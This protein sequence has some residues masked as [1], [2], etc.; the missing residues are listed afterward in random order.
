MMTLSI[1]SY[2]KWSNDS[3]TLCVID[4]SNAVK[5]FN[6]S[7]KAQNSTLIVK[8]I[9]QDAMKTIECDAAFFSNTSALTEQKLINT[10][11]KKNMLSFSTSNNDCEI[12]SS[13]CL[14]NAK[15]GNTIFK[16]NLD[17]LA[18]TKVHVDPRVLLLAKNS[19]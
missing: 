8:S 4:N 2:V 16:V 3:P 1:L 6:L 18:R 11:F 14:Q 17:S 19:E 9:S 12:G 15:N 10:S 5:Q 7:M 13:F